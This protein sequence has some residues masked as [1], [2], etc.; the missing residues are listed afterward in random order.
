MTDEEKIQAV[1]ITLDHPGLIP[2]LREALQADCEGPESDRGKAWGSDPGHFIDYASS[3]M[4]RALFD[5]IEEEESEKFE[6]R[7]NR[8]RL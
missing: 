1:E 7:K 8:V 6:K 5:K 3:I 2:H 4:P